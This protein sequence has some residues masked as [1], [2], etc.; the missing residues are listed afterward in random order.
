MVAT[1]ITALLA[2]MFSVLMPAKMWFAPDQP[3]MVKNDSEQAIV[4]T[5]T[6][7]NGEILE[8]TTPAKLPAGE[9][10]DVKSVFAPVSTGG[11]YILYAVPE[12][13]AFPEFVG[14][15][16]VIGVRSERRPGALEGRVL[17]TKVEPL[18]YAVAKTGKGDLTMVFYYDVAP[19][20]ADSFLNLAAGGYFDGLTFHRIVPGF[21][22]QAGDPSGDSTGG[23]GYTIAPEF[24]DRP[25]VAG[26]LSMAREGDPGEA[27]GVPPRY[28]FAASAGSQFFICLDY[29]RTKQLDKSYTVFGKVVDGMEAVNEIA[30]TPL[31]DPKLGKPAEKQVIEKI[32]VLPVLPGK[33][34]YEKLKL[35]LPGGPVQE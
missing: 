21:V 16:L 9:S 27:P 7:F 4:L 8:A 22:V 28:E 29:E 11:T 13:K 2:T 23:P 32:E 20:T 30:K 5:L 26:T 18:R 34:P 10:I 6:R 35:E 25:H 24:S 33:N 1:T 14:T 17:V 19:N 31:A 15:P 3:L 12:G